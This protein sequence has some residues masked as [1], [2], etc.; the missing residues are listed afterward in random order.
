MRGKKH[1]RPESAWGTSLDAGL[2][3]GLIY[4]SVISQITYG[5]R[6]HVLRTTLFAEYRYFLFTTEVFE[7]EYSRAADNLKSRF[8]LGIVMSVDGHR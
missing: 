3:A 8:V 1:G 7:E 6:F 4:P 5:V 2:G